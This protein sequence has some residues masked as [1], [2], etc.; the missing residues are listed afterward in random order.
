MSMESGPKIPNQ[1]QELLDFYTFVARELPE[2]LAGHENAFPVEIGDNQ[3]ETIIF[4]LEDG[5]ISFGLFIRRGTYIP[6][7][8]IAGETGKYAR[9]ILEITENGE[10]HED[11]IGTLP[12]FDL[13]DNE[14]DFTGLTNEQIAVQVI[15]QIK[16]HKRSN[17]N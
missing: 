12:E 9:K 3:L 11:T 6:M 14:P 8:T 7:P 13:T 15:N 10:V 16:S 4:P 1:K 2:G 17:A 5:K